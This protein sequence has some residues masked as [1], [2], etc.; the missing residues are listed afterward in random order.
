M[1]VNGKSYNAAKLDQPVG[2]EFRP[3]K[4]PTRL[5]ERVRVGLCAT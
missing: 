4:A 5:S 1:N 3:G 2:Y